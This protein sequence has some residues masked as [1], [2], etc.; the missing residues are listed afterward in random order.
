MEL[1]HSDV[2]SVVSAAPT[3]AGAIAIAFAFLF[4]VAGC[5][6]DSRRTLSVGGSTSV[7]DSDL[8]NALQEAFEVTHPEYRLRVV[9]AGSG[10]LLA[11]G[12]R[13]DL[14]VLISHSPHAEL[15]FMSA[16]H[17]ALRHELMENDFVIV[18]PPSDPAAIRGIT[19]AAVALGQLRAV[20]ALFNSR[21][22]DSGTHRRELELWGAGGP[23]LRS[24]VYRELGQ[25]MAAV[26]GASSEL[27]A[28]TLTDRATLLYLGAT[29][30]L[31]VMVEGDPR[32][33]NVYSV[34]V[35]TRAR[36]AEGALAFVG[37]LSSAAGLGVISAYGTERFGEP[38]FR[39]IGGTIP[40]PIEP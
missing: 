38:L 39:P 22:D 1:R 9:A 10:E 21:G 5:G 33:L 29:F 30:D 6:E 18:G 19:D 14:D 4:A 26:L 15:A 11:L 36:E 12:A 37:W 34:I 17:G 35:P 16:G 13:G 20:G 27:G 8:L 40:S 28:Y 23:P 2:Q 32:L 3:W 25:G 24:S 7:H 31:E